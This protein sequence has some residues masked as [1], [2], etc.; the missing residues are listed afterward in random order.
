MIVLQAC[1]TIEV[2]RPCERS[3]ERSSDRAIERSS[4]GRA[5]KRLTDREID[6]WFW[7]DLDPYRK[8]TQRSPSPSRLDL[9]NV[10]Y[11]V[12]RFWKTISDE[13]TYPWMQGTSV[14][15][16]FFPWGE[17]EELIANEGHWGA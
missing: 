15:D 4:D 3:I 7:Y 12:G 17:E 2:Q 14:S 13:K 9:I 11:C 5:I 6:M 8:V 1:T 10:F 16:V